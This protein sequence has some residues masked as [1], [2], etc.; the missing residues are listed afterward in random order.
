MNDGAERAED[1]AAAGAKGGKKARPATKKV[2]KAKAPAKKT[3]AAKP[4]GED[5]P[6]AEGAGAKKKASKKAAKAGKKAPAAKAPAEA[7]PAAGG[8]KPGK[9]D[10]VSPLTKAPGP[11]KAWDEVE[12]SAADLASEE[13]VSD[14]GAALLGSGDDLIGGGAEDDLVEAGA[15]VGL[16]SE[17]DAAPAGDDD[18]QYGLTEDAEGSFSSEDAVSPLLDDAEDEDEDE[19]AEDE[20]EDEAEDEEEEDDEDEEEDEEDEDVDDDDDDDGRRRRKKKKRKK[21]RAATAVRRDTAWEDDE[22]PS[23]PAAPAAPVRAPVATAATGAA[24]AAGAAEGDRARY[25]R[26]PKPNTL[27]PPDEAARKLMEKPSVV[28]ALNW[29]RV[30]DK[31]P[32]DLLR[33]LQRKLETHLWLKEED[34]NVKIDLD[35]ALRR[36]EK[37][38]GMD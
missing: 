8:R 2:A 13:G 32:P 6:S 30:A 25:R 22:P 14:E 34:P 26:G 9:K 27:L 31:T 20:D 5:E 3:R 11:G 36:A 33:E 28:T 35:R 1:D 24:P 16:G 21:K 29:M 15:E 23:R 7:K 12:P 4:A 17:D 38:L 18:I 10:P 19:D 37:L